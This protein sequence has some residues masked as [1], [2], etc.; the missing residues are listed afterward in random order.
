MPVI[1]ADSADDATADNRKSAET[2]TELKVETGDSIETLIDSVKP[3][4]SKPASATESELC[5][6]VQ[7]ED[8]QS[9]DLEPP[10]DLPD[11]TD[12]KKKQGKWNRSR[13]Y[14]HAVDT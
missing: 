3:S 2:L 9:T 6:N 5:N 7:K 14:A 13:S 1:S 4:Q 8:E 11:N 10:D 12:S